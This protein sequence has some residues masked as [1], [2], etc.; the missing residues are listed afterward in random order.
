MTFERIILFTTCLWNA[1]DYNLWYACFT[2][3]A[4]HY[5]LAHDTDA[6]AGCM[7]LYQIWA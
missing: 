6:I 5:N 2:N 3:H 7:Y 1:N 4:I